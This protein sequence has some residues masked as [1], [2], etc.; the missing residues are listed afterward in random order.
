[1][2]HLEG[3]NGLRSGVKLLMAMKS[4]KVG[5]FMTIEGILAMDLRNGRECLI[6]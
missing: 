1:M 4:H 5:N 6:H 3:L 2:H